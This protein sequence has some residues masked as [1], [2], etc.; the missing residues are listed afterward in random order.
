MLL[1]INEIPSLTLSDLLL[2]SSLLFRQIDLYFFVMLADKVTTPF[3]S[4]HHI[5]IC[6]A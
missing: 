4:F 5:N 2:M 6:Y 1:Q 3:T